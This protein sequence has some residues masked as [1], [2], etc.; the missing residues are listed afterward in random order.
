L[1][2]NIINKNLKIKYQYLF[3]AL[4]FILIIL[5]AIFVYLVFIGSPS[6]SGGSNPGG[7]NPGGSNPGPGNSTNNVPFRIRRRRNVANILETILNQEIADRSRIS[8]R[9][10]NLNI[11]LRDS[12]LVRNFNRNPTLP[13][14]WDTEGFLIQ[15]R[16][17]FP[18][19]FVTSIPI[20]TLLTDLIRHL[21][22]NNS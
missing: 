7:S 6:S 19:A 3:Y 22:N 13:A 14:T 8:P 4:N 5:L 10:A 9:F 1:Y 20:N 16:N 12:G 21:R 18:A 2:I 17:E 15:Y 11:T